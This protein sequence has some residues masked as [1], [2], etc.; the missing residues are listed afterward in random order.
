MTTATVNRITVAISRNEAKLKSMNGI[1]LNGKSID[2]LHE[3]MALSF[4]DFFGYQN[5][6]AA[7][8]ASGKLT[9]EEAQTVYAALGGE[10]FA[11]DW[12]T[13]TSLSTK[14]VITQLMCELLK[15]KF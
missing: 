8:F 3:S 12:P 6:Q 7:A 2:S 14:L 11:C 1:G 15:V 4:D 9:F 13:G 5:A 10:S